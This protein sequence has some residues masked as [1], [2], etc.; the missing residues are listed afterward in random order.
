MKYV[1]LFLIRLYWQ[2]VP[3]KKRNRCLYKVSCSRHVYDVTLRKGI[4]DG[5]KALMMRVRTCNRHHEV[6][7]LKEE[8]VFVIRLK[9]GTMLQEAEISERIILDYSMNMELANLS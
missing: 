5:V 8:N 7:Y 9:D 4:V 2:V 1:L 6:V 3:E